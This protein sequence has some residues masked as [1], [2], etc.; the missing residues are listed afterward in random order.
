MGRNTI[1]TVLIDVK[2]DTQKLISGFDRAENAV[3]K[4]TTSMKRAVAGF[5]AAYISL[6]SAKGFTRVADDMTAVNS[7]LKLVTDNT[8]Q[9]SEVQAALFAISQNTRTDLLSNVD[10]YSRLARSTE[11][12]NVS[13]QD[14]INI[15]DTISKSM[16]ISGGSSDSMNAAVLQL[17]QGLASGTL[18]GE[19][20]NSVMEQSPRLARAIADGMGVTIG[21][22]RQLG[23]EGKI[24]SEAIVKALQNQAEGVSKEFISVNKTV[25]QSLSQ[26]NNSTTMII[27]T[28][29]KTYGITKVVSDGFTEL[30]QSIDTLNE[31]PETIG[32][33]A[34]EIFKVST[35]VGTTVV[36][37]KTYNSV[38]KMATAYN[39]AFGGSFGAVNRS[40]VLSTISM[41]AL[42]IVLRASI[43]GIVA[44]GVYELT[45][46]FIENAEKS[47]IL[48]DAYSGLNEN[49][50]QLTK[51][52]LE[53]RK[54]LIATELAQASLN[55]ANAKA[56]VANNGFF[57]SENEKRKDLEYLNEVR[58]RFN[59]LRKSSIEVKDALKGILKENKV[60]DITTPKVKTSIKEP[61]TESEILHQLKLEEIKSNI[62]STDKSNI[63]LLKN[64]LQYTEDALSL[65]DVMGFKESTLRNLQLER[66]NTIEEIKKEQDKN[67]DN[68]IKTQSAYTQIM[69]TGYDKWIETVNQKL[70]ELS[71]TGILTA[72]ELQNVYDTLE[73]QY[74]TDNLI[75]ANEEYMS[76]LDSQIS[77]SESA[78]DWNANLEGVANT[79]QNIAK[80]SMQ[81]STIEKKSEK[82]KLKAQNEFYKLTKDISKDSEQYKTAEINLT[83]KT[84]AINEAS[85]QSQIV[86]YGTLAGAVS[87]MFDEGSKDAAAFH[88]VESGLAMVA[89]IRAILTQGSGDPYTAFARMAA[90]AASVASLLSSANIAFG[91][92]S[93][94]SS[95]DSFSAQVENIGTGSVLGDT[96]KA[97]E[98]ITNSLGILEDYARPEFQLLS[99]MNQ[100]LLSI[101]EKIGGVSAL[102]IQN[103]GFAFGEGYT[104]VSFDD[105]G[106]GITFQNQLDKI[107]TAIDPVSNF[108]GGATD[109]LTGAILGGLFG[110][111]SVKQKLTDYGINFNNALLSDAIEQINGQAYQTITTKIKKKSW[112]HSSTKTKVKTYFQGLDDEVER[113]FSLVLSNLYDS[114][115]QAGEALDTSSA[116][117]ENSLSNFIVSIG[118]ISTK[119]KSG[120][121]LQEQ[122]SNIFSKIG[123]DIAQTAFPALT[124]FQSIGEGLFETLT[125]VASGMEVAEYYI[126]RL[127]NSFEDINYKD[128]VN[129]QGDV[130]VEVLTQSIKKLDEA[131]YGTNNGVVQMI[132]NFSGTTEELYTLYTTFEDVRDMLSLVGKES[133]YLTSDML[134]GAGGADELS[135]ALEDYFKNFLNGEEQLTF[136]TQQMQKEF[137]NLNISMPSSI[138]GFKKLIEGIDISTAEGQ[139]LLGRI[140]LLSDDYKS[141]IDNTEE[142]FY[143]QVQ[144]ALDLDKLSLE[145]FDTAVSAVQK[146]SDK[147]TQLTQSVETT[148]NKL[149]SNSDGANAQ[150]EL[151]KSFWQKRASIDT[152]LAKDGNLTDSEASNLSSLISDINSLSTSIQS[153]QNGDNTD[154]TN[155]L[156]NELQSLQDGLDLDNSILKVK[157]LDSGGNATDVASVGVITA[158]AQAL[159]GTN[160]NPLDISNFSNGGNLTAANEITFRTSFEAQSA[161]TYADELAKLRTNLSYINLSTVDAGDFFTKLQSLDENAFG[162]M[163]EFFNSIGAI[164]NN[165]VMVNGQLVDLPSYDVGTSYVPYDQ[166]AKIHQGEMVLDKNF[167]DSLRR[168]GIPTGGGNISVDMSGVINELK[169]TRYIIRAQ[170]NEIKK[171]RKMTENIE[172]SYLSTNEQGA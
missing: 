9:L 162:N 95:S 25:G 136:Y 43:F 90:M 16:I 147:F 157:V 93:V 51:K 67:L 150:E 56:D 70:I 71:S 115:L 108:L 134:L 107:A 146:M 98:S 84:K 80:S 46:A 4:T 37:Y 97:S 92:D 27:G 129:K 164:S 76:L 137:D 50:K 96:S 87:Q 26:L 48:D 45:Q 169:E 49:L 145:L 141:L 2:A 36:A 131:V 105:K 117:I 40:I 81:L 34:N 8:K 64:H 61:D 144:N 58:N 124:Q 78:L 171:L 126:N 68:L 172:S 53:Y 10:L 33:I 89:G 163:I 54:S 3:T 52:Q 156:V 63:E 148:V 59:N 112:F 13:Q 79:I 14:L 41:K 73:N 151:I 44:F 121:Q 106:L 149:L 74:K 65:A 72:Q 159:A 39:L 154:I 120:E 31:S 83:K 135:G 5:A 42:N 85:I 122:I 88:V 139:E 116:D 69:G 119:G 35:A 160:S 165:Q 23:A 94:S 113:Q 21:E 66:L 18:R 15:T 101:D 104:E 152:L 91:G 168:Y 143:T 166:V 132:E 110:K 77:L 158:L 167:S 111:T 24:T 138:E 55:L 11:T 170:A 82:E 127:G 28:F 114:T 6:E 75:T 22:L 30:S 102:L 17:S 109:K 62:N 38:V 118:K 140:V 19:E 153:A 133:K 142:L 60:K 155:T 47:E 128:I 99:S 123:D 130:G 103:G 100:S 86:G 20:L 32:F 161:L 7:K 125:R 57:E 12:L 1:G 29:D